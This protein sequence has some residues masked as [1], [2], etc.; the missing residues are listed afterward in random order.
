MKLGAYISAVTLIASI[1][2]SG[3]V[4]SLVYSPS[5]Q[6]PTQPLQ[7]EQG[8]VG[9]GM[10]LLPETRPSIADQKSTLGTEGFIR[11]AFSNKFSLQ[12]RYWNDV[13]LYDGHYRGGFSGS[14]TY[15][16]GDSL[17][18]CQYGLTVTVGTSMD[19]ASLTGKGTSV[20]GSV[21]LPKLHN[22]LRPYSSIGIIAGAHSSDFNEWGGGI[23]L[24]CGIGWNI[25][26]IWS[27][28]LEGTFIGQANFYENISHG[29][30]SL[31]LATSLTF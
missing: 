15:V 9:V 17:S 27:V 13:Y 12:A 11:Y 4:T 26:R 8:Q 2:L 31:S 3:C 6:L 1:F 16:F 25:S 14:G 18:N 7:K 10:V 24:Q 22:D 20:V 23:L 21:W 29:I 5:M 19:N 28:N 30:P